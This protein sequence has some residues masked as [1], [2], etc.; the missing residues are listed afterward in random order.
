MCSGLKYG[1]MVIN[2]DLTIF[3]Y[4]EST[5]ILHMCQIHVTYTYLRAILVAALS[6]TWVYDH[7]LAGTAGSNHEGEKNL[8]LFSVFS[9]RG[10]CVRL[11]NRPEN[12][13]Q[14]WCG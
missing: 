2:I 7:S 13:C 5:C 6:K 10:P 14:V 11:I 3:V 4:N 8:S 1:V 9:D 12:S